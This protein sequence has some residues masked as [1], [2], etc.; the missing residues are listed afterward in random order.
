ML[1]IELLHENDNDKNHLTAILLLLNTLYCIYVELGIFPFRYTNN[2][3]LA[4]NY[5]HLLSSLVVS[6]EEWYG[7]IYNADQQCGMSLGNGSYL[8]RVISIF[9]VLFF[10]NNKKRQIR[11]L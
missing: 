7:Q 9:N 6:S 10:N 11:V 5:L 2:C 4:N 3:L 8:D 1:F